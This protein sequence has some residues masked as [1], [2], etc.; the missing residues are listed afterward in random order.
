MAMENS[1]WRLSKCYVWLPEATSNS[2]VY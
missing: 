2:P 1:R